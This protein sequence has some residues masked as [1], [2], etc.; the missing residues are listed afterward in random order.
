MKINVFLLLISFL[1]FNKVK[2]QTWSCD[3]STTAIS[4][5]YYPN[6][7]SNITTTVTNFNATYLCG[8]N[9]IVYDTAGYYGCRLM[10]ISSS[11]TLISSS[12]T[13]L[14]VDFYY[15]KNGG[16]LIIKSNANGFGFRVYYEPLANIIDNSSG[17]VQTFSCSSLLFPSVNCFTGINEQGEKNNFLKIWPNP[18]S[19]RINIGITGTYFQSAEVIII[20]QIGEIVFEN[21]QFSLT[22]KEIPV[23]NFKDGVYF[24]QVKTKDRQQR[25][26][27]VI[28]R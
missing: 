7:T 19:T 16:T 28:V 21:K 3:Q 9:T 1:Q 14:M 11:S 22:N 18:T 20:N 8:P 24:I 26:K 25:E 15:V 5:I 12:P 27:F 2:S 13:C 23:D 6:T 10:L 17:G 4:T